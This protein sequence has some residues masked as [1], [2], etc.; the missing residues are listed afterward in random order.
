MES[1]SGLIQNGLKFTKAGTS[2]T[3]RARSD[4]ARV[5]LEVEDC[6]GGLP[7]GSAECMFTPFS[8]RNSDR[9]GLGL[10]LAIARQ[11]VEAAGGTLS[12]RNLVGT[13]CIFTIDLPVYP[14]SAV[15][16]S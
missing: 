6:C 5:N 12:V 14:P 13:G 10:G 3:L 2:V 1:G 7:A 11:S 8:R 15:T 4:A 9:S 16:A